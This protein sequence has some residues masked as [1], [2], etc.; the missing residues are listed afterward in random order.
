MIR[1]YEQKDKEALLGIMQLNIPDAFAEEEARDLELYLENELEDYFVLE[2]D[3][4]VAGGGGINYFPE[5]KSARIS[6]DLLHPGFQRRGYGKQ[7][8]VHRINYLKN[9]PEILQIIVRTSQ[10]AFRFYEKLGFNLNNIQKDFWA[11]GY[12]LYEMSIQLS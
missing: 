5:D 4:K 3:G 1:R 10:Q 8:T 2:I 6:W 11:K 12:D 7:L 9:N